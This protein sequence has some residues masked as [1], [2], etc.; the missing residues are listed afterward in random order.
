MPTA[1]Q[2]QWLKDAGLIGSLALFIFGLWKRWWVMGYQLRA[3][4]ERAE[5][6]AERVERWQVF[7]LETVRAVTRS[8]TAAE[9]TAGIADRAMKLLS[10]QQSQEKPD[11]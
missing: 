6:E 8:S 7:S 4:E 9:Q 1:E 10:A 11:P 5:R 2:W 3:A